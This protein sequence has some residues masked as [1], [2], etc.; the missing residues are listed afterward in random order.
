MRSVCSVASCPRAAWS[1]SP[2]SGTCATWS[3]ATSAGSLRRGRR[4]P[5]DRVLPFP[6]ALEGRMGGQRVRARALAEIHRRLPLR[7]EARR[8]NSSLPHLV[9]GS[10]PQKRENHA[11]CRHLPAIGVLR[12]RTWRRGL[13]G[14]D[15]ARSGEDLLGRGAADGAEDTRSCASASKRS[16]R[17]CTMSAPG[18]S[19][20]HWAPTP[21]RW[22]V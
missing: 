2:A 9:H 12:Q 1:A 15:E 16:S 4:G 3:M 20:S 10:S 13:R 18:R 21:T 22:T 7:L 19:S 11:D 17:T 8:R 6:A 14:R 5:G